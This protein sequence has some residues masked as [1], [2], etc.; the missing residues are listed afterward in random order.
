M[1]VENIVFVDSPE[2]NI[3]FEN[4]N[5]NRILRCNAYGNPSDYVFS[6]WQHRTEY[7]DHIRYLNDNGNGFLTLHN[8]PGKTGI[9]NERGIYTCS[10]SNG[11]QYEGKLYRLANY[12]LKQKGMQQF[13]FT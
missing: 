2:I 10:V 8:S 4:L 13:Q 3:T 11:I 9:N 7:G 1:I 6:A 5:S 12:T